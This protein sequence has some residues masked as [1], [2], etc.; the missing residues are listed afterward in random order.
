M[1][2]LDPP[3]KIEKH[4]SVCTLIMIKLAFLTVLELEALQGPSLSAE[5]SAVL[6]GNQ[7]NTQ[8]IDNQ[9]FIDFLHLKN[10]VFNP[11]YQHF[12]C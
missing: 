5:F 2:A 3:L 6:V 1:Q 8:N 10:S 12:S 11:Y 7:K 4:S 9:R